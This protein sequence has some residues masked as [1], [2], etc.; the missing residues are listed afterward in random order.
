MTKHSP[1][2]KFT[3]G[4]AVVVLCAIAAFATPT[5]LTTVVLKQNNYAVVAG[6]LTLTFTACDNTNGNSFVSTGREII[7]AQNTDTSS[8]TFTVSSVADALG[9]SDTS[10]TN[11]S[12]PASSTSAIE[13]KYQTGWIQS[14]GQT[15]NLTC[16]SNLIKYAVVQFN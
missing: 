13:M 14:A 2:K 11:Y 15:V 9:R 4:L 12:L 7:L 3:A 5:A 16:S 10:L 6:D 8:H 1:L